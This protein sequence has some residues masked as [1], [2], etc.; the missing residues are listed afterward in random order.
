MNKQYTRAGAVLFVNS[1][2]NNDMRKIHYL[3]WV[4]VFDIYYLVCC[5]CDINSV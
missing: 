2:E 3:T 1:K 5:A 4:Y